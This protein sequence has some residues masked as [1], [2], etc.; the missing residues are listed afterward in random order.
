MT[1]DVETTATLEFVVDA[2]D[3]L[4]KQVETA[5]RVKPRLLR[6]DEAAEYINRSVHLLRK[7]R[8]DG[9]TCKGPDY[10]DLNGRVLYAREDLD[11]WI[12]SLPRKKG[13]I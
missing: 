2:L 11:R 4:R 10:I 6:E 9:A 8:S 7:S 3:E 1:S 12:D 13:S 5:L